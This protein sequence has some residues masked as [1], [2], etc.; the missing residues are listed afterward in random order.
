VSPK[1]VLQNSLPL[2]VSTR[3]SCKLW[4]ASSAA[5]RRA[6]AEVFA[7]EGLSGVTCSSADM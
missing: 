5:T 3:S 7:A 2:S 6:R 4:A 1:V